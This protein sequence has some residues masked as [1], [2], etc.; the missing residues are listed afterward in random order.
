MVRGEGGA[1]SD[2]AEESLCTY[3]AEAGAV[4]RKSLLRLAEPRAFSRI[5]IPYAQTLT[6]MASSVV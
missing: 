2:Y 6:R 5:S 4:L 1:G 3:K